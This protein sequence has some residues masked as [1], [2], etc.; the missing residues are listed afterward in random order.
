[1]TR[2]PTPGEA[3][4]AAELA[5]ADPVVMAP[6]DEPMAVARELIAGLDAGRLTLR[7]WRDGWMRWH[8]AHW[9]EDEETAIRSWAYRQLEHAVYPK[10]GKNGITLCPWLP[11]R[12][13]VADVTDA[14]RAVTH[15]AERTNPPAWLDEST[16]RAGEIVAC[17][18]GLL[19]VGTRELLGHT[20]GFFNLVSVPFGYDP[21]A[22]EPARW[23]EFLHELWPDDP[24]AIAALQE[25]FGYVLS[26][27][28]DLHKILLLIGPTRSG[29]GTI[30]RVLTAMVGHGHVAGPTLASLGTNFGL[31]PLLGKP[32]A[33][34]SDARLGGTD[35][36]QV[37]ERLLSVSGED[38][39]TV[40]RKY[41]EP[42]TGQIPARFLILS[43]ELPQLGDA[44]GAIAARFV[45]LL[46]AQSWLGREDTRLTAKLLPELPGILSWSL[47]G[48]DRLARHGALTEPE[49]SRDAVAALQDLVSPV[50]AFV[51]DSCKRGGEV[52]VDVLFSAWKQWCELNGHKAGSKQRLG[53]DLRAVIPALR[54][55]RP[56][57][58]DDRVRRY[59]GI[60][61]ST[62]YI[63]PDRGPTRTE[64]VYEPVGR[65]GPRPN[66]LWPHARGADGE[67]APRPQGKPGRPPLA[68]DKRRHILDLHAERRWT[69]AQIGAHAGVSKATVHKVIH[70]E[71]SQ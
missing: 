14:L 68:E 16:H 45:V 3:R 29:K 27:R 69:M 57:D 10:A 13:K 47:D 7:H 32:L 31:A 65:D 55:A 28:T 4:Q 22:P 6:P 62:T 38:R 40:D 20:P 48:L 24:A 66:P 37:V 21:A 33:I 15:L 41:R 64:R 44:S 26:G 11:N 23:L 54:V 17:A 60:T 50:S 56:R 63:G 71:E 53:R 18:N 49:S 46:L 1:V 52:P 12:R 30:A 5:A 25:F 39:I 2:T 67:A 61:L 9:A 51:R 59:V 35:A 43:N 34:V 8:R 19:H 42:W 70:A 36:R 58:G